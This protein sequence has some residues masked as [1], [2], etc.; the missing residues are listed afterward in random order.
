MVKVAFVGH[1]NLPRIPNWDGVQVELFKEGGAGLIDIVEQNSK[2]R[3]ELFTTHWQII[4]LFLGGNDLNSCRNVDEVYARFMRAY[5][6]L[7]FDWLVVTEI[8]PRVYNRQLAA[9]FRINTERYETL[10][11]VVNKRVKRHAKRTRNINFIHIPPKYMLGSVDGIHLSTE[12]AAYLV[13]KYKGVIN[14][15]LR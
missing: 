15:Y 12:G 7:H 9:R 6:A 14:D 5:Q 2:F 10:R 13:Q 3:R 1:S 4:V 8:E 11:K